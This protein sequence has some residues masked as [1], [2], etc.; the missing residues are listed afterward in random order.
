MVHTFGEILVSVTGGWETSRAWVV[1][2]C[3]DRGTDGQDVSQPVQRW[4]KDRRLGLEPNGFSEVWRMDAEDLSWLCLEPISFSVGRQTDTWDSSRIGLEPNSFSVGQ[5]TNVWGSSRMGIESI[6]SFGH[7]LCKE[8]PC[9]T[10]LG[11]QELTHPHSMCA[12][13]HCANY[14]LVCRYI[15]FIRWW[16]A[17]EWCLVW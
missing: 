5:Q 13:A 2:G 7:I 11:T 1:S 12:L 16:Y 17:G 14:S 3:D 15:G 8:V 9:L 4:S 6:N 10:V